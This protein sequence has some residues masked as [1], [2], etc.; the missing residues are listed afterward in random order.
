MKKMLILVLMSVLVFTGTGCA[1]NPILNGKNVGGVI[2]SSGGAYGGSVLTKNSSKGVQIASIAGGAL[3]GWLAGS[4]V[5][6]YF[7]E[8]DK[9][10]QVK[11]IENVLEN[12]RDN[13]TS[14]DT[15]KKTWTNPNGQQQ[16]GM[17]TQSITPLRT[18]QQPQNNIY[19][20]DQRPSLPN[21]HPDKWKEFTY[22]QPN[23]NNQYASS[24][25]VCRD[26]Q[27]TISIEGLGQPTKQQFY[28]ACRT[29][30]GW[31]SVN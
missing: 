30:Q 21:G 9:K 4:K 6:E 19:V 15:Y 24:G 26:A 22:T 5:G 12:N 3:L 2:G 20:G 16:T 7:D 13:M 17:V 14:T 25:Q 10:R 31:R 18:F 27:I 28:T 29:E 11:L 8:R 1:T 23:Q